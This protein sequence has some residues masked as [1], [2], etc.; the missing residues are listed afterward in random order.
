M[1]ATW[2][3]VAMLPDMLRADS[4]KRIQESSFLV[5]SWLFDMSKYLQANLMYVY[6]GK[7]IFWGEISKPNNSAIS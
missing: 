7:V 5:L 1:Q 3:A 4:R 2:I 6:M